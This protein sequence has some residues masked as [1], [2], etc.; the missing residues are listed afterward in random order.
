MHNSLIGLAERV[1]PDTNVL[2]N[3]IFVDG[4]ARRALEALPRLR[5]KIVIHESIFNEAGHKLTRLTRDLHLSFNPIQIFESAMS[6]YLF[7]NTAVPLPRNDRHVIAAARACGAWVL[8]GDAPLMIDC[9]R[10]GIESRLPWDACFEESSHYPPQDW[11]VFR[12]VA[13]SPTEGSIFLRFSVKGFPSE[14]SLVLADIE[15]V[16]RLEYSPKKCR[17][18]FALESGPT[19]SIRWRM[20]PHQFVAAA[21]AYLLR[22]ASSQGHVRVLAAQPSLE[23]KV[24]T[25]RTLQRSLRSPPGRAALLRPLDR[26]MKGSFCLRAVV[27]GPRTIANGTWQALSAIPEG[28][29]NPYDDDAL[30]MALLRIDR[31]QKMSGLVILPTDKQLYEFGLNRSS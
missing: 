14:D 10:A 31:Q 27:A 2:L 11:W 23:P 6:H 19:A 20:E 30:S 3:G 13:L 29:P 17:L 9:R 5:L 21:G 22:G 18:S 4:L 8:T 24:A 28:A 15:N 12:W 25:T 26:D 7:A 1:V 16:G